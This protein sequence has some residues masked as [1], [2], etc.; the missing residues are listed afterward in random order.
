MV[1][2]K[3]QDETELRRWFDQGVP[4]SEMVTRYKE[5]YNIETTIA[6]FSTW[7]KRKG[8]PTRIVRDDTLIPWYVLPEHRFNYEV[9]MLRLEARRRGGGSL[10]ELEATRLE[11]W[12]R[13]LKEAG[14]VIHYDPDTEAGFH[15]ILRG[16]GDDEF[17]HPPPE[18]TTRQRPAT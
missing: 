7:R 6:M 9:T 4:Y 11:G 10:S 3:I 16:E 5:K 18:P 15:R 13:V 8:L 17:I 14:A 1:A 12:K 2:R